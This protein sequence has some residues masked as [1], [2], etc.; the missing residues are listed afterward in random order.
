MG[1]CASGRR[2]TGTKRTGKIDR[3]KKGA[4]RDQ[5]TMRSRAEE[6]PVTNPTATRWLK[7]NTPIDVDSKRGTEKKNSDGSG[8]KKQPNKTKM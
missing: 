3:K 2:P 8:E 5:K 7:K 4:A 1:I 6:I